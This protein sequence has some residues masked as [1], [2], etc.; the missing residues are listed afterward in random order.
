[1][2]MWKDV[3]LAQT[4]ER[5]HDVWEECKKSPTESE[6]T[7]LHH[8]IPC[9]TLLVFS[10]CDFVDWNVAKNFSWSSGC[11]C[12]F[13]QIRW[14]L[15]VSAGS[16]S[17]YW[18][19]WCWPLD[20]RCD[21]CVVFAVGLECWSPDSEDWKHS[22][23]LL[24]RRPTRPLSCWPVVGGLQGRLKYSRTLNK[25][26][27]EK[28]SQPTFQQEDKQLKWD[29]NCITI[30]HITLRGTPTEKCPKLQQWGSKV[31]GRMEEK[32]LDFMCTQVPWW[33]GS[34]SD[35]W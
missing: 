29:I 16:S 18:F 25:I 20:G 24:P 27:F 13:V 2:D 31:G 32:N 14:S 10:C 12:Q 28:K 11:F 30:L 22:K 15:V 7:L 4:L 9:N 3:L 33:K 8:A 19:V 6:R 23:E 21:L 5:A 1:M 35:N 34:I 17:C 26:G